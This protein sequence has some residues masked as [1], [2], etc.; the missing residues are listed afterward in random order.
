MRCRWPNDRCDNQISILLDNTTCV[1]SGIL[2]QCPLAKKSM[3]WIANRFWLEF[4]N[5]WNPWRKQESSSKAQSW[6]LLP[7]ITDI[8]KLLSYCHIHTYVEF[9]DVFVVTP[10]NL[11]KTVKLP[12]I[13]YVIL[14]RHSDIKYDV[15]KLWQPGC[16]PLP[17]KTI[18]LI[19]IS[20][21]S[22]CIFPQE[23]YFK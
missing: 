22:A 3:W 2:T 11:L 17:V 4:H 14:L 8:T 7:Y 10:N 18:F 5:K 19:F 20:T 12:V 13:C 6:C 21:T 1:C 9:E 23:S 15:C 16:T